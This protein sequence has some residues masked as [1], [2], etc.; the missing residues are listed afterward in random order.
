[1]LLDTVMMLEMRLDV[2]GKINHSP[3]YLRFIEQC[4][5]TMP[6]SQYTLRYIPYCIL[7]RIIY[8]HEISHFLDISFFYVQYDN[9]NVCFLYWN[10]LID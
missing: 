8:L 2:R 5:R 7:I 3:E 4:F 6:S 10:E 1:M 9:S